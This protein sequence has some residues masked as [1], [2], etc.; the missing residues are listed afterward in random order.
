MA[1]F[2]QEF[3]QRHNIHHNDTQHYNICQYNDTQH[4]E[5]QYNKLCR[6]TKHK[7]HSALQTTFNISIGSHSAVIALSG[8]FSY[9][10]V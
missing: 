2:N 8:A 7:R 10:S 5:I 1:F 6:D 9:C 3:Y 4:N